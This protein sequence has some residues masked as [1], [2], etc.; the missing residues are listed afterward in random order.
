MVKSFI[1]IMI[2]ITVFLLRHALAPLFAGIIIAYVLNPYVAYLEKKVT[3]KKALCILIAYITVFLAATLLIFG[4][5]HIITGEMR[6][7][8]FEK[9]F[10]GLSAYLGEYKGTAENFFGFHFKYPDIPAVIRNMAGK[11]PFFLISVVI[12]VY[13]LKD[14]D[15]FMLLVQKA[16]H[17]LLPQKA[18]GILREIFFEIDKVISAFLRGVFVDSVIVAFLS[19]V[20]LSLAGLDFAVFLGCFAGIVD[21]IPYF[22]PVIGMIPAAV[23][24]F[25]EGGISRALLSIFLL[26]AIQQIEGNFIYPKIIGKSTGL[27]PLFVLVAVSAAGHFGGLMWMV[28]AVPVAGVLKVL[29]TKWAEY[30]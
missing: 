28:L 11:S 16:M 12:S 22:G 23:M 17:L 24:G 14:K 13:L 7:G 6:T 8:S 5:A 9:A 29:V 1:L 3:P 20:A 21:I 4:F 18:H 19:S 25:S 10:S 26:G 15:V 30:Q 27:H 2:F